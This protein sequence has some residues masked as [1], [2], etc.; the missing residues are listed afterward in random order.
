[1]QLFRHDRFGEKLFRSSFGVYG[2]SQYF[3]TF[4]YFDAVRVTATLL[5]LTLIVSIISRG[6]LNGI[7]LVTF[8]MGWAF[9]LFAVLVHHAWTA[10]FQAQGRYLLPLLPMFAVLLYHCQRIVIKPIFY[11][12]FSLLFS[13]SM[14]SFIFVGLREIGK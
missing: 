10:D 8:S 1:M 14:Y 7:M 4:F 5:L 12:L 6:G 9:F 11:S 13:F 2:Y 3:G